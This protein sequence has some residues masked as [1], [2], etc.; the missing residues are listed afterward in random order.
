[1]KKISLVSGCYNEVDNLEELF[2][3]ASAVLQKFPEYEF[4]YIFID[5]ASTD[6][7]QDLLRRMATA[8]KRIKVILNTRNFGHI[9]SPYYGLMQAYGDAAIYLASDLQDPPEII[10]KFIVE[11]QKG[12]KIVLAI[13]NE[14]EESPLF[15]TLRR[16]YYE[17]VFRMANVE[18][19]RNAT[20]FGLYD[21]VVMDAIR[22]IQDPYPYF[23][24]LICELGYPIARIPFFQ[25]LR[26]R[27]ITKANFYILYDMAMLGITEHSKVPLRLATML[28]F[29][30]GGIS[31]LA[32]L[33]YLVYKLLYW[34]QFALGVAPLMIGF[35][36]FGS[37]QLIFIG[38]LGEYIGSIH[39]R[40]LNRPLVVEK[41]RINF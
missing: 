30:A 16:L 13:K 41:E 33:V 14:T 11:W 24:G 40:L 34:Q 23:R 18:M 29:A 38:M 39:T 17:L 20:G 6:G 4:E 7:T 35:F 21:R 22:K 10:E 37:I 25:P 28:G 15:S 8:D 1:M 3:Q 19:I 31:F 2:A 27:G 5:N 36:F 32:G 26:K 9:R 12:A